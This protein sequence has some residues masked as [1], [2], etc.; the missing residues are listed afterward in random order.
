MKKSSGS[1]ISRTINLVITM[2]QNCQLKTTNVPSRD[3]AT[4][5]KMAAT[6]T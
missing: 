2:S 3:D 4:R 5:E 1:Q 6:A